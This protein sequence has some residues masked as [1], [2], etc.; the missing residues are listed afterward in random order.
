MSFLHGI[1]HINLKSDTVPVNDV[2][3]AVIGL[4]GTADENTNFDFGDPNG[5]EI[6]K[7]YLCK[8]EKDDALFGKQGTIPEALKAIRQQQS[9]NGSTIVLV[10]A[11]ATDTTVVVPADI[12]GEVS[13]TGT[14]TGLKL[15][16]VAK[17]KYGF[18][19]MIFIA[20]HF[21]SLSLVKNELQ[22]ICNKTEA[23]AYIDSPDG[24]TF[25][26]AIESRGV[27]GSMA[28]L[29]EGQML[30]FPHFLVANPAFVSEDETPGEEQFITAPMSAYMAGLRAK[31]DMEL[32]WHW[33]TSNQRLYG[34]EGLDVDL[35]FGLGD[36]SCDV[37]MLNAVGITTAVPMFGRGMRAWG[38]YSTGFPGN[39]DVEA[40]E[41]VRRVRSIIKRAIDGAVVQ[42]LGQPYLQV[43]VDLIRNTVNG[44]FNN[45]I[46]RGI[47]IDGKCVYDPL[48]N[49]KEETAK[50]HLTFSNSIMPPPPLQQFTFEYSFDYNALNSIS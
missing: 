6:N 25:D 24:W 7:L 30:Y 26:E 3:T 34:V 5:W 19:A 12:V 48:K 50:G 18:E 39:T 44:Y 16:E 21:S 37:N 17:S 27:G 8:S 11:F 43:V 35:T 9:A 10:V 47:L 33:S 23:M 1:E 14:R 40:F 20:P 42:F 31:I 29:D 32:G 28:N 49:P 13:V 45:L 15:F 22:A 4:I 2:A 41:C 36:R 38:N 46:M